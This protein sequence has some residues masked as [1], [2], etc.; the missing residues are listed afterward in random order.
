MD[1]FQLVRQLAQQRSLPLPSYAALIAHYTTDVAAYAA[2]LAREKRR[3]VYGDV[4]FVRGLM[5]ISN[6]CGN[7]C[8]YCGIRKSNTHCRRYAL[9]EQDIMA[10][11]QQGYNLGFRTFVLQGGES[12][13]YSVERICQLARDIKGA[14][15]GCALTLSL[16]EYPYAAYQAMRQAGADRYL[17]RHETANAA[18]YAALHPPSMHYAHRMRCLD[19]LKTLGFQAGCGFMVGT[20]GQTPDILAEDLKFVEQYAPEMCG[21]GPFIPH[22]ETPLGHCPA[23]SVELTLFLLSLVRLMH[24]NVLLPA[25][26]ALNTLATDGRE[27]GIL[28]GANVVMPNLSPPAQRE[29]Y[30]LYDNKLSTGAESAHNLEA[31]RQSI[32]AAGCRMVMDR[33]D[34]L[35]LRN[36]S[37]AE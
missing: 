1:A 15:P 19:D 30:S 21:I 4:V 37:Y 26:T 33:G 24:P 14:F 3:Q 6:I 20:P 27:K 16:G 10:C 17:L 31:L 34:Y 32:V 36:V 29:K 22:H 13:V 7:D 18:H 12:G 11:C 9:S 8:Y 2:Q 25:T 5:E 28:A 35:P 23:G